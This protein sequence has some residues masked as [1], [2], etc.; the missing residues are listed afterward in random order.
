MIR[1]PKVRIYVLKCVCQ[2]GNQKV[3]R[4]SMKMLLF[5]LF[6]R[7]NFFWLFWRVSFF[8]R[9]LNI[10]TII[11]QYYYNWNQLPSYRDTLGSSTARG[12]TAW[13]NICCHTYP[14]TYKTGSNILFF[15]EPN[16]ACCT[17]PNSGGIRYHSQNIYCINVVQMILLYKCSMQPQMSNQ[18]NFLAFQKKH[19]KWFFLKS[20]IKTCVTLYSLALGYTILDWMTRT[21]LWLR[22]FLQTT[23]F[24]QL[25]TYW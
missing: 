5:C 1:T 17:G 7:L 21:D 4:S 8:G 14:F 23:R 6:V 12:W 13:I 3:G 2:N 22:S 10:I 24:R 20:L 11:F 19:Y 15:S 9:R 25:S 18:D 16:K